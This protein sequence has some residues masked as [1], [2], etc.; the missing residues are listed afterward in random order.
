MPYLVVLIVSLG[1]GAVVYVLSLRAE[2]PEPVA[3][4]FEP[5][6]VPAPVPTAEPGAAEAGGGPAVEGPAPGYAYLQVAITKGPSARERIQGFVGSLA[7]VAAAAVA[8][9]AGFY[10]A[11]A[12]LGRVIRSFL[13]TNGS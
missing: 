10:A 11:G 4:G 9:A 2:E 12:L 13:E 7:L 1:V 6:I 8:L 5:T 3:I